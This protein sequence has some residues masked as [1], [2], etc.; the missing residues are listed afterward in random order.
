MS[1][2]AGRKRERG[3]SLIELIVVLVILGLLAGVV[4]PKVYHKLAT[5][6]Q[7]ITRIQIKEFEGSLQMFS[8]DVGRLPTSSEGLDALV[9]RM[10]AAVADPTVLTRCDVAAF[11]L[12]MFFFVV[13]VL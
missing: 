11:F 4:G 2:R 7:Q 8:F 12:T 5:G 6:K 9:P 1:D 10:A 3:F 13:T